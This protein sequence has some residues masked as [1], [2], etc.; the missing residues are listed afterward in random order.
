MTEDHLKKATKNGICFVISPIGNAGTK[1]RKQSDRIF[2]KILKPAGRKCGYE[3][4][5]ADKIGKPGLITAQIIQHLIEDPLVIADLTGKDP[6]VLYELAIRHVLKK[7][8]VQIMKVGQKI[9]FDIQI[10]RTIFFNHNT[11]QNINKCKNEIIKQI[12]TVETDPSE[13]DVPFAPTVFPDTTF[14]A[15]DKEINRYMLDLV[16]RGS[17]LDIVS[18]QLHWIKDDYNIKLKLI[19][20]S[21]AGQ[22]INIYIP[23]SNAISKELKKNG[24]KI[25][26]CH[27][28]KHPHPRFTI[29][30]K[31]HLG[32]SMLAIAS[33]SLPKFRISEFN[34]S[35]FPQV[36]ALAREYVN[37]LKVGCS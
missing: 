17:T 21:R 19:S 7:P 31:D 24:I 6:N 30:D 20:R 22:E 12:S 37:M 34:E 27:G 9:P 26:I 23:K 29:V 28:L 32:T 8:V 18:N 11:K 13:A 25:H 1:S 35:F 10:V 14:Y 2:E 3:V 36:V 4:I 33:G 16:T 5:R 15:K